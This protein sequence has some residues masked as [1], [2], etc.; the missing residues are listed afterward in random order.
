MFIEQMPFINNFHSVERLS[1]L[2][3]SNIK[4]AIPGIASNIT[5]AVR[6]KGL[7]GILS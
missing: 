6:L 5:Q 3:L 4:E 7:Q 1:Y 2:F